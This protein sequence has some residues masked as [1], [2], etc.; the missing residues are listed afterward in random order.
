MQNKTITMFFLFFLVTIMPSVTHAETLVN[1][2]SFGAVG[3]GIADD[4]TA[5]Q[6]AINSANDRTIFLP[7]GV[8][9]VNSLTIP[10]NVKIVG[11][12]ATIKAIKNTSK[13]ITITGSNIFISNLLIDGDNRVLSGVFIKHGSENV[14]L[15][16]STIQNISSTDSTI[17]VYPISSGIRLEGTT[18]NITIDSVTIQNV[19]AKVITSKGGHYVSRGIFIMSRDISKPDPPPQNIII[20]NCL[21]DGIGPKDDGDGINIQSYKKS[22]SLKI[23]NNTFK[24]N[25]KRAIKIQDDGA[26]I[27]GNL[28]YNSFFRNNYYDTYP[29]KNDY[30]MYAAISVYAD[31]VIIR[32]NTVTGIGSYSAV[33]DLD[34]SSNVK[35]LNNDFSNG[36]L[37]NYQS[38]SLI[39]VNHARTRTAVSNLEVTGNIFKNGKYG[40]YFASPV[41]STMVKNNTRI[42]CK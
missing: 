18:K 42:N 20:N 10:S 22:V 11:E 21:I 2:Q 37:S 19:Y 33:I 29:E 28:I 24:N 15:T 12:D 8:Y 17:D 35:V 23:S 3:N 38:Y 7:K 30:D 5:I 9:L 27:E 39:R 6:T 16:N 31:N 36:V 34:S 41:R 4:T 13:L 32:N 25:H 14:S 26:I 40:I 1:V